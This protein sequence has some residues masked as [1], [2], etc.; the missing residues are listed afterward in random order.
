[1]LE[2]FEA[3]FYRIERGFCFWKFRKILHSCQQSI[4]RLERNAYCW[5][6]EEVL[7]CDGLGPFLCVLIVNEVMPGLSTTLVKHSPSRV[8][9]AFL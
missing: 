7:V 5:K 1:M 8:V 9:G 6:I 4:A 3:I 2:E